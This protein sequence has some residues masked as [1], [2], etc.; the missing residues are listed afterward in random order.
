[1]RLSVPES[2]RT[3][4]ARMRQLAASPGMSGPRSEVITPDVDAITSII[5][6]FPQDTGKGISRWTVPLLRLAVESESFVKFLHLLCGRILSGSAPGQQFICASRVTPVLK[7]DGGIPPD[8]FRIADLPRL[9]KSDFAGEC[10][11]PI[12]S[13]PVN[14][15]GSRGGVQPLVFKFLREKIRP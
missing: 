14:L 3:G 10:Q 8:S 11:N 7:P 4:Q 9:R 6:K 15:E 2:I 5:Y 13:C 1:M 12:S